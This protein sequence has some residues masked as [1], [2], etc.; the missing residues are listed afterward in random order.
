MHVSGG[1]RAGKL[2][3]IIKSTVKYI[4]LSIA[5]L[6]G[7]IVVAFFVMLYGPF[8]KLRDLYVITM[9]ET[10]AA[11][12]MATAFFSEEKIA[13]ILANNKLIVPDENTDPSL[14]SVV[15]SAKETTEFT[16]EPWTDVTGETTAPSRPLKPER[17]PSRRSL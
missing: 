2:K 3:R 15:V 6:F 11:K 1:F 17:K 16:S 8:H 12:F 7:L 14:V 4:L 5:G 9:L 10:S 13:E